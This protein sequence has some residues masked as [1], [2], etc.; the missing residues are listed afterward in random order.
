LSEGLVRE[1]EIEIPAE[2]VDAAFAET[3]HKYSKEAKIP[4]FR[5][6][7]APLSVIK[8]RFNDAIRD[9]VLNDLIR[10]SYPA[11]VK[12]QNLA[13][14]SMP[15][16]PTFELKEGLPLKYIARLEVM[17][18]IDSVV[19]DGLELPKIEIEVKDSEVDSVVE[20]LQKKHS[21][22]RP[23]NRAATASD[24]L[25]ADLVK[26]ED[27]DNILKGDEFKGN[28]IDLAS[29]M[30]VKEFRETLVGIKAGEE[31]EL[32]V[33]Y[34]TDYSDDRFAGKSL[35]YICR[36]SEVKERI[37][38]EMTDAFAKQTG[39]VE[40]VLELRLKIREDL[41]KQKES[42]YDKAK[43]NDLMRQIL[44]KNMFLIPESMITDYLDAVVKDHKKNYENV[45]EKQVREQ[46]RPMAVNWIRWQLLINR[47]AEMEKI[48]VSPIDTEN[49][50]KRFAENY[51]MEI[52][53]AKEVLSKSG[54]IQ[55]IRDSI[56]EDKIFDFLFQKVTYR[57]M[58]ASAPEAETKDEKNNITEEL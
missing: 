51:R 26:L 7:K 22:L 55:E 17:P 57:S 16:I 34:P 2:V 23:V 46:Y 48:E 50:I 10:Q 4:G 12:E 27:P 14:A 31:R 21:E 36:V 28:E 58:P 19:C 56:L 43:R 29:P 11:A 40:T 38:P 25:I 20:Y 37:L 30:T 5:P 42:D 52:D 3:Y 6:G 53:K 1:I 13:V 35:K 32:T 9:D 24:I 8:S 45:E 44:E 47:L 18:V 33:N 54:R 41:K 49:W 15:T 39:G